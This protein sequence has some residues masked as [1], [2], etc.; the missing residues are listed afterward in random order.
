MAACQTYWLIHQARQPT[1]TLATQCFTPHQITALYIYLYRK[2]PDNL[3]E[4][5]VADIYYKIAEL[6][7]HKNMNNKNPPGILTIYRG[8]K[9]LKEITK[10]YV[11]LMSTKT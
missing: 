11:A 2:Q 8:I 10:M 4:T 5:S 3:L 7:G 1:P 9:K 6:G